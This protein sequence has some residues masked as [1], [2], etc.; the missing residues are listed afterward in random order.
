MLEAVAHLPV[1]P[2]HSARV[3]ADQARLQVP[4]AAGDAKRGAVVGAFTIADEALVSFH[5]DE[6]EG[7]P[8]R[9][10]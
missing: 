2:L 9:V 7:P 1:E 10:T 3:L 4:D 8:H 5:L 6:E